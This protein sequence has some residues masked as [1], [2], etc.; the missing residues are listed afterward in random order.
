MSQQ[1]Q[2]IKSLRQGEKALRDNVPIRFNEWNTV[3]AGNLSNLPKTATVKFT[4]LTNNHGVGASNRQKETSYGSQM[5]LRLDRIEDN[6]KSVI[7][8]WQSIRNELM[9]RMADVDAVSAV[10]LFGAHL[11]GAA[12]REFA[13]I[14]FDCAAK[15]YVDIEASFNERYAKWTITDKANSILRGAAFDALNAEETT[16]AEAIKKWSAK[17]DARVD[18]RKNK[19]VAGYSWSFPPEPF[20]PPPEKPTQGQ[21]FNWGVTGAEP[22]NQCAWL[23]S[24]KHGWE[25]M[26]R[27]F[28]LV[29]KEV[30]VLAFKSF[31]KNCG[32]QQIDYLSED[33]ALDTSH[34]LKN[35]FRLLQAHSEAQPY[36]P[37]EVPAAM[38]SAATEEGSVFSPVRKIQIV[39]SACFEQ[40][41]AELNNL[42]YTRRDDFN[43]DY[44][45]CQEKFLLAEQHKKDGLVQPV[46]QG[47]HKTDAKKNGKTAQKKT[48]NDSDS[49]YPGKKYKG[50]CGYCG[51]WGHHESE[52]NDNPANRKNNHSSHGN[53]KRPYPANDSSAGGKRKLSKEEFFAKMKAKRELEQNQYDAYCLEHEGN[54]EYDE[55]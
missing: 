38:S 37:L 40:F 16:R 13:Q 11:T 26:P 5:G 35:F 33:L 12:T 36:Y 52:C 32:R 55:A 2:K 7:E 9:P 54:E 51:K 31:G 15:L 18:G 21:F 50:K 17:N 49:R 20:K 44:K 30:Q 48:R 1:I 19:P 34:T 39:W 28:D 23:R 8:T 14:L 22:L 24:H 43:G 27:F 46:A 41:K 3:T 6:P 10:E 47:K 29:F 53:N 45:L 25:Y 42:N 4:V